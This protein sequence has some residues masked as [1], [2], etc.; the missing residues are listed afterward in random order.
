[1]LVLAAAGLAWLDIG[2]RR[3]F[4]G[5]RWAI[6]AHVYTRPLE[7]YAGLRLGQHDFVEMLTRLGYRR[8][9]VPDEPGSFRAGE[10]Q[11]ELM[12]RA[13]SY[14]DGHERSRRLRVDFHGGRVRRITDTALG[15]AL[16]IVR[17]EAR[18]IGS[19]SP[20]HHED[21]SLVRLEDVPQSLLTTLMLVEDRNFM[22]HIGVDPRG[23]ARAVWTNLRA[24]GV[25][26][27]G[28][29]ITQQLVKNFYLSAERTFQRKL[30]EMVM[31]VLLELHYEK[32]EILQAYLN[33]VFLGQ[34]G[35]RAIHG[36]GLAS[37]FYF[38][39]P[40]REL[41]LSETALLVG[42][43]QAPSAYDPRRHPERAL[44]RRNVVLTLLERHGQLRPGELASL[45]SAPLGI[46]TTATLATTRY[47]A[48]VD[49]VRRQLRRD[50][51]DDD[52]RSQGLAIH[53]T[54]DPQVQDAAEA[55]LASTL[56]E[57][58]QARDLAQGTLE[59]AVVVV[60]P[61]NGEVLAM[62][63]GRQAGFA[64][65]NRALDAVRPIGSLVKPAVYA[66]A[67]SEPSHYTL[68]TLLD[69]G[70]L[71]VEQRGS[72]VWT[73]R[74]YDGKFHGE[75]DALT[76][77]AR[78]YN[79]ATARLG[80]EV[81][82]TNVVGVMRRMGIER[83]LVPYPALLL[84]AADLAPVEVAQMYQT[85]ASGGFRA[86]LRGIL[87]VL[88]AA[89]TPLARYALSV[90]QVIDPAPMYLLNFALQ[91][92]VRSGTASALGRSLSPALNVAGKTGTTDGYRDSWFAGY[93]GNYLAVVWVGRDDNG[94]TGLSGASGAMR[95]WHALMRRLDLEPL[96]QPRP[97]DIVTVVVD[98]PSGKLADDGCDGARPLP[99]MRGSAPREQARCATLAARTPPAPAQRRRPSRLWLDERNVR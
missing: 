24:G 2:V 29:T 7:L 11:V 47:P 73:P 43:V 36:F 94:S 61:N 49:Y 67:L 37:R 34:A 76:A 44:A 97:E 1:M 22:R 65:F 55:A 25:V 40:L 6:P 86:P 81:G 16:P 4:E 70:P 93:T 75:V 71:R 35:N 50:Y 23:L 57:L 53:T 13:N 68:A 74:N 32:H 83:E 17:V 15:T 30:K 21:R 92:V 28:S 87:S 42:L 41:T 63:G 20:L 31:A 18:L 38:D 95:V 58:D 14:W 39:R 52:L 64:G 60:R 51:R 33:E 77:L 82:M 10:A 98:L 88:S 90:D 59:G 3:Q 80:L 12:T 45:Q 19:I 96:A 84:G 27:G 54:L 89:Q 85:L 46:S 66:A 8:V 9:A 99:F 69:D 78:S 62:V 91:E 72:P 5:T 79:V 26:Q 48:F 56:S